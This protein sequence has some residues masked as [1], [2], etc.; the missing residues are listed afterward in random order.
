[1]SY[2]YIRKED[3]T[4]PKQSGFMVSITRSRKNIKDKLQS[5]RIW[6]EEINE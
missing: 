1:M 6:A 3:L 2:S 5:E 4:T